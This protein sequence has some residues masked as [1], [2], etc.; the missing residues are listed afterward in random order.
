ME[1]AVLPRKTTGAAGGMK[2]PEGFTG[3]QTSAQPEHR[4]PERLCCLCGSELSTAGGCK[5][6]RAA[7]CVSRVRTPKGRAQAPG[8]AALGERALPRTLGPPGPSGS[9]AGKELKAIP[10]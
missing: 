1:V 7:S 5:R 9:R 4:A 8:P 2:P 10:T 3:R 6:S